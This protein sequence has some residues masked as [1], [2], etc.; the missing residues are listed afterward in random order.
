MLIS[1]LLFLDRNCNSLCL[2]CTRLCESFADW[3]CSVRIIDETHQD[4]GLPVN[5]FTQT[6]NQLPRILSVGDII[7][8]QRVSVYQ[9]DHPLNFLAF[10]GVLKLQIIADC[11]SQ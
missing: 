8:F 2:L 1:F 10:L 6:R 9:T 3:F 5:V 7:Q 4:P 11:S